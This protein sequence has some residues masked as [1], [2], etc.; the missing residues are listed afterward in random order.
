MQQ[1]G[2]DKGLLEMKIHGRNSLV[3]FEQYDRSGVMVYETITL[4]S[5]SNDR[6]MIIQTVIIMFAACLIF[7]FILS[8]LITNQD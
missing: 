6:L 5:L 2:Q 3:A 4:D 8:V 1:S 7:G